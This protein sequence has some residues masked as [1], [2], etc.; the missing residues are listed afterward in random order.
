MKILLILLIC[1]FSLFLSAQNTKYFMDHLPQ[2]NAL[3]PA[4]VPQEKFYLGLPGIGGVSTHAFNSGFSYNEIDEFIDNLDNIN[5]NPEEF[6]QSIGEYNRFLSE[7]EVNLF[8]IGFKTKRQG[9]LSFKLSLSDV[10]VNTASSDVAYLLADRDHIPRDR[11]P[12]VIDE[13]ELLTTNF[14]KFGV[15]YAR[16][17]NE[18]LTLGISPSINF[19]QIGISTNQLQ[20]VVELDDEGN[21]Y[22]DYVES[23]TGDASIGLPTEMN[24]EA[25]D[26]GEFI[27]DVGLLPDGWEEDYTLG[28]ALQNK[29]FSV[30][31]GATYSVNKW[32]FSASVLNLGT[33]K[34]KSNAYRLNGTEEI[35]Y[36][37]EEDKV[38]I[39]IPTRIYVGAVRQFNPKWNYGIVFNN[40]FYSTGSNA[41]A[42]LSLNGNV[43]KMLSTSVSYTAGFNYNNLGLGLRLRFLPGTDLYVVTDNIIQVFSYKDANR[44]TAAVGI[45]I[46]I[47]DKY[48]RIE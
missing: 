41:S 31:L 3:N 23:F 28:D 46:A 43:G 45:N 25:I 36:I 1:T 19:S 21:G 6:I 15:T 13:F 10:L 38:K 35:I 34:W 7:A 9:Y 22:Y 42:T 26:N 18:N 39:G 48:D 20:Y 47:W 30:D 37:N 11:F 8:S 2:N 40:T 33:T 5:Y 14:M 4:F 27:T 29:N 12:L 24:P 44:L 17:I 32:M 16:V